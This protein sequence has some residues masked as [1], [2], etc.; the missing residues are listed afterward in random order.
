MVGLGAPGSYLLAPAERD[1][2]NTQFQQDLQFFRLLLLLFNKACPIRNLDLVWSERDASGAARV[3]HLGTTEALSAPWSR[4]LRVRGKNPHPRF[5]NLINDWGR[6]EAE[7]CAISDTAAEEVV[8]RSGRPYVYQCRFG[9]TDIAVPVVVNG[10]HIA[11][12]FTGQVLREPPSREGF[13]RIAKKAAQLGYVNLDQLAR[14]YWKLPV[15]SDDDIRTTVQVV[16]AFAQCL[17]LSWLRIREVVREQRRKER[18]TALARKELAYLALE[19]LPHDRN[20]LKRLTAHLGIQQ[21]LN[22]VLVVK[23]QSS[24]GGVD[25]DELFRELQ[26]TSALQA[27]EEVC[28]AQGNASFA[29]LPS[30]EICVF[31][32]D[33]QQRSSPSANVYA[34]SLAYRV[35]HSIRERSRAQVRVGIGDR[36]AGWQSLK[37]SYREACAALVWSADDIAMHRSL[38][39]SPEEPYKTALDL[40]HLIIAGRLPEARNRAASLSALIA[41]TGASAADLGGSAA[42]SELHLAVHVSGGPRAGL[43][44]TRG[45]VH[46]AECFACPGSGRQPRRHGCRLAQVVRGNN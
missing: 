26:S 9:L 11:T 6:R 37:K 21:P 24:V 39:A 31:F 34:R 46:P 41:R 30:G 22:R 7:S 14:A 10:Q 4:L 38:E 29:R 27:V 42:V 17:G 25:Q 23:F 19:S 40:P 33:P 5:C 45:G 15:V 18:E 1:K 35:L 43:P 12:L 36:H 44:E 32:H 13:A 3:R 16:E 2:F 20:E 8:R 28:E